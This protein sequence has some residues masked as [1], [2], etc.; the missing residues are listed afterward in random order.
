MSSV[1][2]DPDNPG[3]FLIPDATDAQWGVPVGATMIVN[4]HD[5]RRC[6]GRPCVIHHPSEHHMVKWP[7]LWRDDIAAMERTCPH[8]VG[9]PDPDHLAYLRTVISGGDIAGI[10]RHG[11]DGCCWPDVAEQAD[12]VEPR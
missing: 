6:E 7:L 10:G 1:I 11:C 12:S 8:G 2:P 9:H 3:Q 5:P 4:V